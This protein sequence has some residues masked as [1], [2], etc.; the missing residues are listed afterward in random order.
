MSETRKQY[1]ERSKIVEAMQLPRYGTGSMGDTMAVYQWVEQNTL[2]SFD[3]NE[4][5]APIPESGVSIDAESGMMMLAANPGLRFVHPGD[6]VVRSTDGS[7]TVLTK[8]R[9]NLLYEDLSPNETNRIMLH[10]PSEREL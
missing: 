6:Y 8:Q 9:F 7:F 5:G 4:R 10:S 3:C 2:G 1:R